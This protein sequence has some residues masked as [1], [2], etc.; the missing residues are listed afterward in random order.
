MTR[1]YS[2]SWKCVICDIPCQGYGNNPEPVRQ[3]LEG[4]CCDVCN[5][6][7]VIPARLSQLGVTN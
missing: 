2:K 1:R 6:T 7:Q 4:R 3:S 5:Q